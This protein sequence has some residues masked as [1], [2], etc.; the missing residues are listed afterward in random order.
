MKK[1]LNII[2]RFITRTT[3]KLGA[4]LR[5]FVSEQVGSSPAPNRILQTDGSKSIWTSSLSNILSI[6][7]DTTYTPTGTEE[8]GTIYW[9]EA[10]KTFSGALG[11]NVVGQFFE[12]ALFPV[13][14]DTGS[15]LLNGKVVT[16]ASSIGNSGNIRVEL[17]VASEDEE[18]MY[19]IGIVTADILNGAIGK[20]T[21]RGKV[22]GIQ[23]NGANYGETWLD[24]DILYKSSTIAGGLTKNPPEAP[25][26]AIP[27]AVVISAH[28][29]NGTLMVRPIFPTSIK[30]LSDVDGTPLE[31]SGQIMVW[32]N[33]RKVFDFNYNI[34]DIGSGE[35]GIGF[36]IDGFGIVPSTTVIG[37]YVAKKSGTITGWKIIESNGVSSSIVLT[38]KKNGTEIS[39]TEK[40]TLSNAS[41]AED[42]E[43]T[44]WTTS[45][46]KGDIISISID[47]VSVGTKFFL[48]IYYS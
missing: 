11:D 25:I 47:S 24:G 12:E 3:T 45:I 4:G 46:A 36:D 32:D 22:R 26:P 13:Q 9:D 19:T 18:P 41:S 1:I 44:T 28:A 16:Y 43:L 31:T 8:K 29:T 21:T 23:T 34:N 48:Q 33:D 7:F 15:T 40:P 39:G 38:V 17:T 10:N 27:L 14:N 6:L 5:T 30:M 42:T 2:W 35:D 37:S 20:V